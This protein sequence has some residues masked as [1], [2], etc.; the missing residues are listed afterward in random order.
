MIPRWK[1]SLLL[2]TGI[3]VPWLTVAPQW[4][5][6]GA[7]SIRVDRTCG[8]GVQYRI[9]DQ[10]SPVPD[11]LKALNAL[12]EARGGDTQ[13]NVFATQ[14]ASL[15]DL[16]DVRGV[17]Q[18]VGFRTLRLFYVGDDRRMMV[19]V[20]MDSPAIPYTENPLSD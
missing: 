13:V 2:V 20:K 9:D 11:L 10:K 12:L 5:G 14:K 4:A 8:K 17:A 15:G 6:D 1:W 3:T 16:S 7:I 18:K 19:E